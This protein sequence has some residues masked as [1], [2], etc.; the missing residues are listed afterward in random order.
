MPL[1]LYLVRH[2][3][4][5][6][7]EE[8]RIQGQTDTLLSSTGHA[9]VEELG[10]WLAR[11]QFDAV[12]SSDLRRSLQTAHALVVDRMDAVQRLREL[13]ELNFG[14]WEGKTIAEV[15]TVDRSN[16]SRWMHDPFQHAPPGGET[17]VELSD[18][19]ERVL[20]AIRAFEGR[21]VLVVSHQTPIQLMLCRLLEL[22]PRNYWKL[23]V[24][25]GSVTIVQLYGDVAAMKLFNFRPLSL[26][27]ELELP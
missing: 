23:V 20:D 7:N 19:L 17:L 21:R 11:C 8:G 16:W 6:W 9:E 12:V 18:R 15:R 22:N 13:R 14:H 4:T 1:T 3:Q 27:E 26:C 2:G 10:R 25:T 5:A 24:E